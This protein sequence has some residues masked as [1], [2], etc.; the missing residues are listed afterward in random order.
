MILAHTIAEPLEEE[1]ETRS[2]LVAEAQAR[3]SISAIGTVANVVLEQSL[4]AIVAK[5]C[6]SC[7]FMVGVWFE[8]T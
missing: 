5:L 8:L 2:T 4:A 6:Q 1:V 3:R 7:L